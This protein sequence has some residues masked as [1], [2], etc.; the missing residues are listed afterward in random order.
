MGAYFSHW[1]A[2]VTEHKSGRQAGANTAQVLAQDSAMKESRL[3]NIPWKYNPPA[4]EN[5]V[6][7]KPVVVPKAK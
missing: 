6:R 1:E 5:V 2:H 3:P 4:P 7:P